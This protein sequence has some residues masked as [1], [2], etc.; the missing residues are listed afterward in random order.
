MLINC[1]MLT[2]V[3]V[4]ALN[5]DVEVTVG[6]AAESPAGGLLPFGSFEEKAG[7]PANANISFVNSSV[8]AGEWTCATNDK[9][10][11]TTTNSRLTVTSS[12]AYSGSQSLLVENLYFA[13]KT[14][15]PVEKGKEYYLSFWWRAKSF[16]N[17]AVQKDESVNDSAKLL[18]YLTDYDATIREAQKS[19]IAIYQNVVQTQN[20][21]YRWQQFV[22]RF[23]VPKDF[24]GQYYYIMLPCIGSG[25]V[26]DF[27]LDDLYMEQIIDEKDPTAPV[28][29]ENAAAYFKAPENWQV[30]GADSTNIGAYAGATPTAAT[31]HGVNKTV[32]IAASQADTLPTTPEQNVYTN[33]GVELLL[34]QLNTLGKSNAPG[35]GYLLRLAD[36]SFIVIDGGYNAGAGK[37]AEFLYQSMQQYSADGNIH[38][39]AWILTHLHPDHIDGFTDFVL[40]Y[41]GFSNVAIDEV[42]FSATSAEDYNDMIEKGIFNTAL[43]INEFKGALGGLLPNTRISTPH[44]GDEYYLK[45]ARLEILSTVVDLKPTSVNQTGDF[46]NSS[47]IFNLYLGGQKILF[48]ADA[49]T[50]LLNHMVNNFGTE[51]HC[52]IYQLPHHG[53]NQTR[54]GTVQAPVVLLPAEAQT[55]NRVDIK[56]I[57]LEALN[58]ETT[59]EAIV[60]CFG[61]RALALPYTPPEGLSNKISQPLPNEIAKT[62]F[63]HGGVS[64]RRQTEAKPQAMRFK[65]TVEKADL[66]T[67]FA[68]Y[69][70]TE[71]GCLALK[72]ESLAGA[73]LTFTESGKINGKRYATGVAYNKEQNVNVA[74]EE[75]EQSVTFAAALYNIGVFEN[76]CVDY[77]VYKSSFCV[78]PYAVFKN[79]KGQEI[80]CYGET[81]KASLFGVYYAIL[82]PDSSVDTTTE[83]YL[84]DKAY[85]T[86]MLQNNEI[87]FAYDAWEN[88]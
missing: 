49:A 1:L 14:A 70:L 79:A 58:A 46:N 8:K 35:M 16:R 73:E 81:E 25:N 72:E 26:A 57:F 17:S 78:R 6:E 76:G 85:V 84:A 7:Y 71:Y 64:L 82:N 31:L 86:Q 53:I 68:G 42:I 41:A 83:Q 56:N 20:G 21:A 38:I 10:C 4:L 19:N 65:F 23:V 15:L 27:Y 44:S 55:Y 36:G 75:N 63:T 45:N 24:G 39:T 5:K 12:A 43:N 88:S 9:A 37:Q 66:S 40:K 28:V 2:A 48:T 18:L 77:S 47:L 50:A 74:F 69:F 13:P 52:D 22:T 60:A 11:L 51:L 33:K 87:K 61:N 34:V 32:K 67:Y 30:N 80:I 54:I 3:P 59:K 62:Y 29:I